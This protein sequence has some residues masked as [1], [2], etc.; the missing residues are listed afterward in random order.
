MPRK[1]G[2]TERQRDY[3]NI[4]FLAA[5]NDESGHTGASRPKAKKK[6]KPKSSREKE[7]EVQEKANKTPAKENVDEAADCLLG[8]CHIPKL[9]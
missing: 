8:C 4:T 9:Y 5:I 6:R 1:T 2:G 7:L 3:L